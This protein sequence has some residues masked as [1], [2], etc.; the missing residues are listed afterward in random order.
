[1]TPP[2]RTLAL[3]ASLALSTA[4]SGPGSPSNPSVDAAIDAAP[5]GPA[6][7]DGWSL[8]MQ[9]G[10]SL[11]PNEEAYYC[12]YVTIREDTYIKS[13]RPLIPVGTHHTVLTRFTGASPADGTYR[14]DV[15]T[16]GQS[17]VYGSGVGTP[18]FEFPAGVGLE[19]K[20]G[21]RLLLNLHLYNASDNVLTGTSGTLYKTAAAADIQHFAEIVLAGPTFTLSVPTGVS[22]QQGGCSISSITD[23]PIQVFALSQHMHKLGTHLKSVVRRNG[24]PDITLQDIDYDFEEQLFH[25]VSPFVE[26][27]PGDTLTTYCTYNN[28]TGSLVR[29]GDSSDDEMCFTDM[30]YYPAQGASFICQ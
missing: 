19:L 12:V 10:W 14:C 8:L 15:G 22:T 26:L 6:L 27:R 2:L 11:Q 7:P 1:M 3:V 21:T 23:E 16:N 5:D 29:F 18:D 30:F 24:S 4:C 25:H 9:G 13:F 17:M 20:A 28:T